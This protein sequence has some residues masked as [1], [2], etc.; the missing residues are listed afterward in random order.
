MNQPM[1]PELMK[2]QDA[3]YSLKDLCD[4]LAPRK[5]GQGDVFTLQSVQRD[6]DRLQTKLVAIR[7]KRKR[8]TAEEDKAAV[9]HAPQLFPG[10]T[11]IPQ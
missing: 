6:V 5:L 10:H 11:E 4:E 2:L 8:E 7:D 3:F 1:N 9:G